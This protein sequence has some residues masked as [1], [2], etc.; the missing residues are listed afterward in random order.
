MAD[1]K[2][3]NISRPDRSEFYF[4]FDLSLQ[5]ASLS[6]GC[7]SLRH[8]I[9]SGGFNV[10]ALPA[11]LLVYVVQNGSAETFSHRGKLGGGLQRCTADFGQRIR[12]D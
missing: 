9:Y 10:L 5:L 7:E 1:I 12:P 11:T 2:Q 8:R 4:G 3:A 6:N